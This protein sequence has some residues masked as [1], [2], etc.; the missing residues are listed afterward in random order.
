MAKKKLNKAQGG[1]NI[2]PNYNV[3]M[4]EYQR[5]FINPYGYS[6]SPEQNPNVKIYGLGAEAQYDVNDRL[7][8]HGGLNTQSVLYPGGSDMFMKPTYNVGLTYKFEKGGWLEKY[9]DGGPVQENYN[10]NTTSY[11]PGFV[12]MGYDTQ[13]RNYSPAWGGQFAMGG[14]LPGS[15][16]FT[17]ARTNS[18]APS[19]GPYAKKTLPSA[20]NGQEMSFYQHG[21]DW[22]PRN[23]SRDGS[24]VPK[25]QN[26]Q[27]VLPRYNMPR[28]GSDNTAITYNTPSGPISTA[29]TGQK[30]KDVAAS[31]KAM[32][33]GKRT[34]EKMKAQR[35]AERKSAV[36]AK[37]KGEA[38]TLPTGESKTY[39]QMS[40]REQ[41]YVSGKALEQRGRFNENDEA[42]Y[43]VINPLNWI[44]EGASSL[45]R[46]PLEAKQ[47]N[48]ILPYVTSVGGNLLTGALAGGNTD[49]TGGIRKMFKPAAT[50]SKEL[51]Q[52][53]IKAGRLKN[54]EFVT[55]L[56]TE[57]AGFNPVNVAPHPSLNPTQQT[58][59]GSWIQNASKQNPAAFN[60]VLAYVTGA[61]RKQAGNMQLLS[62][63]IPWSKAQKITGRNLPFDA[64]TMSFGAGKYGNLENALK[65]GAI[66]GRE[67]ALLKNYNSQAG[68]I[69]GSPNL[70]EAMNQTI[71]RLRAHPE[72][73]NPNEMLSP[74]LASTLR[75]SPI[76][77]GSSELI[78]SEIQA[79]KNAAMRG[80][81]ISKPFIEGS[82]Q[83]ARGAGK[84]ELGHG[85][86]HEKENDKTFEEGGVI[87][88]DM[89]YWNPDNWGKVVEIDSP[90]IT[91][92][93]V[94]EPL[95]GI[96]KQTGERKVMLP[97][98]DYTFANTKQV[99]EK[100]L[101]KKSTGGW[102][103]KY[104]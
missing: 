59:T 75:A 26:A 98:K 29:T 87:K 84:E 37:D 95:E 83:F 93:D 86:I 81:Y 76:A 9:N 104:N 41:M 14:S 51:V 25:N 30:K 47:S 6:F 57:A 52:G 89:G 44:G 4:Q 94:Y 2:L 12:G 35:I 39:E 16:G 71:S 22:T 102:L 88:D 23:I 55:A 1:D 103:D 19:E 50:W 99:I 5:P 34:E 78:A 10:D 74:A 70:S 72:L 36:A 21:L 101:N 8:L 28:A 20:Q 67:F 27:Y 13:G 63:V 92:Q 18:P 54:P 42:W 56:R 80:D 61:E 69:A 40:P 58:F 66:T 45:A 43:D 91:M 33:K 31:T 53:S 85:V 7:N 38:F 90:N 79:L 68:R 65:E 82:K 46:A 3:P 97:G 100:P 48:S 24:E 17:Y 32:G 15:V 11:P 77:I 49:I 73:Y 62:D 64:K 60:E 96:S